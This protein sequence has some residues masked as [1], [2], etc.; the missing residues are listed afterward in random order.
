MNRLPVN[1]IAFFSASSMK[2]RVSGI[3]DKLGS[4]NAEVFTPDSYLNEGM[5]RDRTIRDQHNYLFVGSGGTEAEIIK[6]LG[7]A[8]MPAPIMLLSFNGDNS[9]PAA[10]EVRKYLDQEK[11]EARIIHDSLDRLIDRISEWCQF[12][13]ILERLQRSRIGIFGKPSSWLVAS[14]IDRQSVS[15]KW[16]VEFKEY[17]I[18][19][20]VELTDEDLWAEFA[21]NLEKFLN[22]ASTIDCN[23]EDLQKVAIIAQTL[24]ASAKNHELDAVTLECFTLLEESDISGCYAVSHMNTLENTVAGCEGDLPTVFSMLL[25]KYLTKQSSFMANVVDV[26][27]DNNSVVFA[28]C[29]V[30]TNILESYDVTTHFET[31]KS[32]AIRGR[33]P[34]RDITVFKM[35]GKDLTDYWISEGV[36]TKNLTSENACRTQ[37]RTT[38]TE[39]VGYFLD[40]SLANHHVI[41]P[42]KH[43]RRIVDFF[44]FIRRH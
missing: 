30:P 26:N 12:N 1:I 28:H 10:M 27:L 37:I 6:F 2:R 8:K 40:N 43:K 23:N 14:D 32:V 9:L 15:S 29:T 11:T 18:K 3:M 36:I 22:D 41:I 16:G 21:P 33:F 19:T 24:V 44:N 25:A 34:F 20:L 5:K 13:A 42:G 31:E 7:K 39:S 38:L 17:P 35:F 4:T